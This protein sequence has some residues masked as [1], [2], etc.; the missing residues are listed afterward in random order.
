MNNIS[1]KFKFKQAP[2]PGLRIDNSWC[3]VNCAF[4]LVSETMSCTFSFHTSKN[5]ADLFLSDD[6]IDI[7]MGIDLYKFEFKNYFF[8]FIF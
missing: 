8:T 3:S 2:M 1:E 6:V 7:F 5:R 4:G